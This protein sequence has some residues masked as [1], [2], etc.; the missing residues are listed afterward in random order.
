MNH[1]VAVVGMVCEV[2]GANSVDALWDMLCEGRE[3]LRHLTETEKLQAKH[4]PEQAVWTGGFLE[5]IDCFDAKRFGYT[6][7]DAMYMDPQHRL[8]LQACADLLERSG[9]AGEND[10][11]IGVFASASF[12]TW[13]TEMVLKTN[14]STDQ[15][16]SALLGNASDCLATRISF[17]L[18]L[19]GPAMTIQCGCSSSLVAIH[20]ARMALLANQCEAAIAGGIS[21]II[22]HY[23]GY[24]YI[25]GGVHSP[26][27]HCKPFSE[28]AQGTVFSSGF[29]VVL[30]KRLNDAIAQGDTIYAVVKGSAINN[31]GSEKASFT[32]PGVQG[33]AAVVSKALRVAKLMPSQIDYIETHGTGTAIGDPLEV[34]AL[35]EVF[36]TDAQSSCILGSIKANIGHLD[37]AAGIVGFVKT[38]LMLHHKTLVPQTQFTA[39]NPRIN[40]ANLPF[41]INTTLKK[42]ETTASKIRRAGV[43]AFGFGGTN[44]H[45][46]LE[47]YPTESQND[48]IVTFS[49]EIG[50]EKPDNHQ[51]KSDSHLMVFSAKNTERLLLDIQSLHQFLLNKPDTN[52]E[53]LAYTLQVGR[54]QYLCRYAITVNSLSELLQKL[55]TVSMQDFVTVDTP[56]ASERTANM[57]TTWLSGAI[58]E[59]HVPYRKKCLLPSSKGMPES[60][61]LHPV[62][63]ESLEVASRKPE[64][65]DWLY[66]PFWQQIAVTRQTN[67]CSS[68]SWLVIGKQSP[69]LHQFIHCCEQQSLEIVHYKTLDAAICVSIKPFTNVVY[70]IDTQEMAADLYTLITPLLTM[71]QDKNLISALAS[72]T[73]VTQGMGHLFCKKS[74]PTLAQCIAFSRGIRQEYPHIASKLIDLDLEDEP[75]IQAEQILRSLQEGQC[76]DYG[77]WRDNECWQLHY[78]PLAESSHQYP[79]LKKNGV[80]IITGGLGDV[81]SV[82]VT[83]LAEQ[84]QAHLILVGRTAIPPESS[85]SSSHLSPDCQKKVDRLQAWKNQGYDITTACADVTILHELQTV[86]QDVNNKYDQ[87]DGILHIAGAG[88]ELHYKL[89]PEITKEHCAKIFTPKL[90]G[91]TNIHAMM[92]QFGIA[93][94]LIVSSISS[95]LGG[96]GLSVYAAS[97]N[98]LDAYVRTLYPHWRIMNWDAW[99]FHKQDINDHKSGLGK[100]LDKLAI[101][102][103]EGVQIL[104]ILMQNPDW[105]QVYISS[106]DLKNRVQDWVYRNRPKSVEQTKTRMPRPPLASEYYAPST[107]TQQTLADI[108]SQIMGIEKVG[109]YDNFFELGGDSLLALEMIQQLHRQWQYSGTVMDIFETGTIDALARKI[110]PEPVPS[111]HKTRVHTAQERAHKQRQAIQQLLSDLSEQE[112]IDV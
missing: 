41:H 6:A 35:T 43:S 50:H 52:L 69:V 112:K 54:K 82:Y 104:T 81:A 75:H 90:V 11:S 71:I 17:G 73:L 36:Q 88:S 14:L 21:V 67:L 61:W 79:I 9:N 60:F 106:S 102:P 109:I 49:P 101:T 39:W 86:C 103:N 97:H 15:Y 5:R 56:F 111:H 30:L 45:V 2:P 83:F 29:G 19:T 46:I 33:Q 96:I 78:Q 8:F 20:Q 22:P 66:Q 63:E 23:Q 55:S 74:E 25:P 59:W 48:Y 1:D 27:G 24:T 3:G 40:T 13:L 100:T 44:A 28:D 108:W 10:R 7:R 77:V 16:Q 47:E 32:A 91:I 65:N 53:A 85:W 12:N 80:Y 99:N 105:Q 58:V 64:I 62:E 87:I 37:V 84:Y 26:D 68:Q 93:D 98:L 4:L 92:Q 72:F 76:L 31:D 89:L 51:E 38:C 110:S 18:N 95:A 107:P 34:A 70:W 94:C 42:W 57:A